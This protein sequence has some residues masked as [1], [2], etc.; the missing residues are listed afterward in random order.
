MVFSP[1]YHYGMY[2]KVMKPEATYPVMVVVVDNEELNPKDFSP[3]KWDK[4]IQPVVYYSRHQQ[5]NGEM[6][7][8]VHR[9]TGI[10]DSARYF[11]KLT[12]NDFISW[13]QQYLSGILGKGIM[14]VSIQFKNYQR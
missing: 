9:L 1:F 4:V 3:Q 8:Q 14:Q 12:K 5:W 13:Y 7:S 6:F 11:N 2:S 10:N